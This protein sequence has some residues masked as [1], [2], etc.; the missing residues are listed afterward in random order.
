MPLAGGGTFQLNFT[1]LS[2]F[3][4]TILASS[5]LELP[6]T[7]WTVLGTAVE[8]PA[9]SYQFTD[10]TATNALRRFNRVRSP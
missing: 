2:G 8:D 5:D 1:N 6:L 4:F 7:N 10:P 3:S 9:G